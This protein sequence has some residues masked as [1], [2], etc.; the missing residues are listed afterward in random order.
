MPSTHGGGLS[1][2]PGSPTV[3]LAHRQPLG[4]NIIKITT[5]FR[6]PPS[7][8]HIQAWELS[9]AA[10]QFERNVFCSV[11]LSVQRSRISTLEESS[12]RDSH[13][14]GGHPAS[15]FRGCDPA[16]LPGAVDADEDP[17]QIPIV[18]ASLFGISEKSKVS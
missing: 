1:S 2:A 4:N 8:V 13:N 12:K 10:F 9:G 11:K 16:F 3:A 17:L 5:G 6:D 14:F 15:E 18:L 7:R